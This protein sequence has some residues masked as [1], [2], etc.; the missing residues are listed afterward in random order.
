MVT[1][2]PLGLKLV[3]KKE[4]QLQF[5]KKTLLFYIWKYPL[6]SCF[7]PYSN[8]ALCH[9]AFPPVL[10]NTWRPCGG[11]PEGRYCRSAGPPEG[12]PPCRS[13]G[14]C[15]PGR[16][17][18]PDPPPRPAQPAW[19]QTDKHLPPSTFTGQFLRKAGI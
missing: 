8:S 16:G 17:G 2:Y 3:S 5:Y 12:R 7:P 11:R 15:P 9:P 13:A 10:R 14:P 19:V 18:G 4:E 6:L 1:N